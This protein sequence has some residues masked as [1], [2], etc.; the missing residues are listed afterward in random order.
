M[1]PADSAASGANVA[2]WSLLGCPLE[3]NSH[4]PRLRRPRPRA[5][6]PQVTP[7]WS[8]FFLVFT[9]LMLLEKRADRKW[10]GDPEYE[11]YKRRTPVLFP[12]M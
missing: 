6:A 7:L 10:G 2:R 5:L 3:T 4:S 1:R 12:G 9:S 11:A 8:L